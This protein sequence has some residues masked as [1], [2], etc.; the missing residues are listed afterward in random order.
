MT[1]K[2][3]IATQ[4]KGKQKEMLALL[5]ESRF[6]LLTPQ[7]IGLSLHINETGASYAENACLKARAFFEVCQIPTLADDSGLEVEA[8]GGAPGLFSAR[9]SPLPNA[10]DADRRELL[11][12]K[13]GDFAEPWKA[14]FVCS[15]ALAIQENSFSFSR[16]SCSGTIIAEERGVNGFGFDP[17][18]LC[19][20]FQKTMAELNMEEKNAISHRANAMRGMMPHLDR[21]W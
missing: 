10:T 1:K 21:L 19:N 14:R 6:T 8:L 18:F 2:I 7:D 17:I 3:L 4:N 9:F 11:L 13:L 16:G 5:E 15:M 12:K 20:G